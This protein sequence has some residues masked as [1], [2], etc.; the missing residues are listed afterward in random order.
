MT[1]ASKNK[2]WLGY[3]LYVV[4]VAV[5]LLYYLFPTQ[6]IAGILDNSVRSINPALGFKAEKIGLQLPVG[7]SINDGE[8][9]LNKAPKPAIFKADTLAVRPRVMQFLGGN[10]QFTLAGTAYKGEL[11][12]TFRA[13]AGNK[14]TLESELTFKDMDLGGYDFLAGMFPPRITGKLRGDV[15]FSQDPAGVAAENGKAHLQLSNG[16]LQFQAPIFGISAVDM[17]NIDLQMQLQRGKVLVDKAKLSGADV[18]GFMAGTI[19]LQP[20]IKQSQL[21]LMGTLEPTAEFY[22]SHPDIQELLKSM[23]KR[24]KRGQYFFKVTGTLAAPNFSL[25]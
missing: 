9:Y 21:D 12:G 23:K 15:Q 19:Q 4:L 18:K 10:Y 7:L 13:S 22:Q 24:V 3:I 14:R 2:K 16:Q 6:E 1:P 25:L 11:H 5:V 20:D 17:Q 8:I